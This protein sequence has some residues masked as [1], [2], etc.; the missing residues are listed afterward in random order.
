M[1][2]LNYLLSVSSCLNSKDNDGL[3]PLHYAAK[4]NN[5]IGAKRLLKEWSIRIDVSS[6]SMNV[7]TF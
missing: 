2:S 7:N 6:F 4:N 5:D 3:T 1:S